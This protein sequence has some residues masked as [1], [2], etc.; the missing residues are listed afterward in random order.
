MN[1]EIKEKLKMKIAISQIKNEEE[2]AMNEKEKFVFKNVGIA[3][4]VLMSLTGVAFAGNKIIENIWKTPEKIQNVTD[5]ITEESKKE[6][7]T[8]EQIDALQSEINKMAQVM[9]E[10][11]NGSTLESAFHRGLAEATNNSAL[12]SI[13]VLCED[14]LNSTLHE[15][16][17]VAKKIGVPN[18]A[19]ADHQAILDAVRSRNKNQ[20]QILMQAHMDYAC[21]NLHRLY[22]LEK[23]N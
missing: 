13:Y 4:C 19:V 3:A 9:A 2:K 12:K 23:E 11:G 5:K 7:I 20:A 6:N 15:T 16:W 17:R 21:E 8:E 22:E 18:T 1:D 10:G 14:L